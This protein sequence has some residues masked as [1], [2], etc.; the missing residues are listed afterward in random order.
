MTPRVQISSWQAIAAKGE[1]I[2]QKTLIFDLD[3]TLIDSSAS[4]LAGFDA[5]LRRHNVPPK[6][7]LTID[8][9]GPPLRD[10]LS[11]LA[12]TEVPATIDVLASS[13]KD[14]YDS[15]GYKATKVFPGI[16]AM[17]RRADQQG[18]SLHI[19][20]NKRLLPTQLILK[21]LG[22][23]DLFASVYALDMRAPALPSKMAMLARQLEDENISFLSAAY[24]G[25]RPED[26][27]AAD[28][29]QLTFYAAQWGYSV[30]PADDSTPPLAQN[31]H[32]RRPPTQL[33]S[34][35]Y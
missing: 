9:I 35:S 17:L 2:N 13:F 15:N 24:I 27:L 20:T 26:G 33:G 6:R 19:A 16:E 10:T 4:I 25:D 29:N 30:F 31:R 22:W 5:A 8:I 1:E 3:G 21:H 11:I 28:A 14:Y 23:S 7:P 12:G 34:T 18:V 32:S